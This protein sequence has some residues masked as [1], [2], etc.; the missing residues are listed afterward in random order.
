MYTWRTVFRFRVIWS[1][2]SGGSAGFMKGLMSPIAAALYKAGSMDG[3]FCVWLLTRVMSLGIRIFGLWREIGIVLGLRRERE[4]FI[5]ISH[6]PLELLWGY[7]EKG[8]DKEKIPE[9]NK[10]TF[11]D[12]VYIFFFF[13]FFHA[14]VRLV[15]I[16]HVLC[17]NSSRKV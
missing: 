14:F 6:K 9:D 13:F 10:A 4:P 17:M 16:V 7:R 8:K 3:P 2:R 11:G 1:R 15:A 5:S 12:H